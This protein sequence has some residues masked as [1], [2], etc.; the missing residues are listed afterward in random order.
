[1][2][3]N[4]AYNNAKRKA[5]LLK[6]LYSHL[7]S[8]LVVNGIFFLINYLTSLGDWWFLYPLIGWGIC[9][10]IHGMDTW[11]KITGFWDKWEYRKTEEIMRKNLDK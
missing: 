6:E 2:E 11:I 9:L 7:S 8:Y 3:N 4:E 1:M 5:G 10:T